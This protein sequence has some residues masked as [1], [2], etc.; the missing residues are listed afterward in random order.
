MTAKQLVAG[1]VVG[2]ATLT[3]KRL[4]L[5]GRIPINESNQDAHAVRGQRRHA[6]EQGQIEVDEPGVIQEIAWRI[7]GCRQLCEDDEVGFSGACARYGCRDLR[8]ILVECPD[9][10][11]QLSKC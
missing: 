4:A 2:A 8:E 6:I 3:A 10:E 1:T 11:I 5:G 9:G 7:P